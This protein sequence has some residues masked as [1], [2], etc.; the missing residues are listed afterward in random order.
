MSSL[1]LCLLVGVLIDHVLTIAWIGLIGLDWIGLD[2]IGLDWIGLD[3][4]GLDW[5]G[6]DWIGLD[7]LQCVGGTSA[8]RF[9]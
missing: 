9:T 8:M 7:W 5:I 2:W 3:W 4:I 1:E 6:L